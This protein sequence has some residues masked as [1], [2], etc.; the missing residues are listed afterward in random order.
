MCH[1]AWGVQ[2]RSSSECL[3]SGTA[4]SGVAGFGRKLLGMLGFED[5][6]PPE[7]KDT[8]ASV[9]A[10]AQQLEATQLSNGPTTS[11]PQEDANGFFEQGGLQTPGQP[12]QPP[13]PPFGVP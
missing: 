6:L 8:S 7:P 3:S 13:L 12:T 5:V 9:D 2:E 11:P 1:A 4:S 10:A